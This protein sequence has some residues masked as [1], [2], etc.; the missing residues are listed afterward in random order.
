M[1]E[2]SAV[3]RSVVGSSPTFGANLSAV[4]EQRLAAKEGAKT[5]QL[6]EKVPEEIRVPRQLARTLPLIW[7]IRQE[8]PNG[9]TR[10]V[11]IMTIHE[12]A[13]LLISARADILRTGFK[14]GKAA[15]A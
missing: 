9:V 3:N 1:V 2:Q 4:V 5:A 11:C 8:H 15:I 12:T 14:H 10:P 7:R 6:P 13:V